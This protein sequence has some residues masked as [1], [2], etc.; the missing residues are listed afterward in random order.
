MENLYPFNSYSPMDGLQDSINVLD[1]LDYLI[2]GNDDLHLL[3]RVDHNNSMS[4]LVS[5]VGAIR[6]N[7]AIAAEGF[8]NYVPVDEEDA[9][10]HKIRKVTNLA[11]QL[12]QARRDLAHNSESDASDA[13]APEEDDRDTNE[14]AAPEEAATDSYPKLSVREHAIIA[15]YRQGHPVEEIAKAVNLKKQTVQRMINQLRDSGA[16]SDD[17]QDSGAMETAATA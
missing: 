15:T 17:D 9:L 10:E 11:I 4:G 5:L 8:E 13:V 1:L 7:I 16:I 3:N 14:E 2:S 6:K 12:A